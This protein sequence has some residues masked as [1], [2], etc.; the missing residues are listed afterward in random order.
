MD[1]PTNELAAKLASS[2]RTLQ[3]IVLAVAMGALVYLVWV[4]VQPAPVQANVRSFSMM[5]WAFAA[6]VVAARLLVPPVFLPFA[7]RQIAEGK[8]DRWTV[9]PIGKEGPLAALGEA[10]QLY[11]VYATQ[12]I[13]GVALIEGAL[14]LS[15][16]TYSQGRQ[17]IDLAIGLALLIAILAHFPTPSRVA[18]WIDDQLRRLENERQAWQFERRE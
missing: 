15:I 13:I 14:F 8:G 11:G 1:L 7:R 9:Q 2:V 5:S 12:T 17:V 3:V 16:F 6:I 18:A 10:G 4:I